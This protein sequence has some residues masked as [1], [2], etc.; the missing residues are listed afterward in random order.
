MP[1]R[2]PDGSAGR[3]VRAGCAALHFVS[4]HRIAGKYPGGISRIHGQARIRVRYLPGCL[5]VQPQ[6]ARDSFGGIPAARGKRSNAH[7]GTKG[8]RGNRAR[9]MWA[10]RVSIRG[11]VAFRA[12]SGMACGNERGG[13][14]RSLP[15]ER[16]ETHEVERAGAQ[17]VHCVGQYQACAGYYRRRTHSCAVAAAGAVGGTR[18]RGICPMG[19]GTHPISC[20]ARVEVWPAGSLRSVEPRLLWRYNPTR[21]PKRPPKLRSFHGSP[22][23]SR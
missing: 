14:S 23:V 2:M 18:G 15:R 10:P 1:G 8:S 7:A 13:V 20:N 19:L 11:R 6:G 3:A 5:P 9:G 12:A 16:H 4:E 21:K 22:Q 17:R